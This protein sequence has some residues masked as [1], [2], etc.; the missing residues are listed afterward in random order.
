MTTSTNTSVH[1]IM[2]VTQQ[3]TDYDNGEHKFTTV[4]FSA[5][6]ENGGEH[7][8]TLFLKPEARVGVLMLPTDKG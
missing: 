8:F 1:H 3:T 7:T 2:E 5:I 4:K 6:D